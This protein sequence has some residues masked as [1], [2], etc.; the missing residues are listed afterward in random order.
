MVV[1]RVRVLARDHLDE[2]WMVAGLAKLH[3]QVVQAG[4]GGAR[5]AAH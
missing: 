1:V 2:E 4:G 5:H 3:L